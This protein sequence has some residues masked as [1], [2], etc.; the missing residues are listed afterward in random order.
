MARTVRQ[1]G[2]RVVIAAYVFVAAPIIGGVISATPAMGAASQFASYSQAV[3]AQNPAAYYPFNDTS[4]PTVQDA[5]GNGNNASYQGT[6]T[7]G[8][9]GVFSDN[10]VTA[11]KLIQNSV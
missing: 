5:S 4:S 1:R 11:V 9:P 2:H 6:L 7:Y 3:L 8:L 10:T